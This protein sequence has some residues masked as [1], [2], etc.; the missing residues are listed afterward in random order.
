MHETS[1]HRKISYLTHTMR[2]END[3]AALNSVTGNDMLQV[4]YKM[5]HKM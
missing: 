4:S 1:A 2:R 3:I 5:N